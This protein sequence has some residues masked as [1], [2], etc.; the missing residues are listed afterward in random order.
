VRGGLGERDRLPT[1]LRKE[2]IRG[3]KKLGRTTV[4]YCT[5]GIWGY[6]K[7]KKTSRKGKCGIYVQDWRAWFKPAEK[8][9]TRWTGR[10][11][12]KV[13]GMKKRGEKVLNKELT[14]WF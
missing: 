10:L 4:K 1:F 12:G 13:S 6:V 8:V 7:K 2:L 11:G 9:R 3:L 14:W 5:W